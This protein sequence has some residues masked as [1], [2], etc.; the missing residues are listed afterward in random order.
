MTLATLTERWTGA[1]AAERANAQSYLIE[2][3]QALGV[4]PPRPAGSGYEF[5]FPVR[6]VNRD[7]TETTNFIDLYR[8]AHFALEAKDDDAA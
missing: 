2:L 8:A 4:E 1:K 3:C 7:G 6:V 5:E